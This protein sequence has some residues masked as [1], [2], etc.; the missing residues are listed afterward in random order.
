MALNNSTFAH[1][2]FYIYAISNS[3][4][5]NVINDILTMSNE[6]IASTTV[7]KGLNGRPQGWDMFVQGVLEIDFAINS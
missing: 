7:P 3:S 6:N 2:Q 1:A 4:D 5:N